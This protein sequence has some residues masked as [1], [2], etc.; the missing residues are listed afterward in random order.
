M[1]TLLGAGPRRRD[2]QRLWFYD[3]GPSPRSFRTITPSPPR[4]DSLYS[5]FPSLAP[6]PPPMRSPAGPTA[7]RARRRRH[8][9]TWSSAPNHRRRPSTRL[10]RAPSRLS[11]TATTPDHRPGLYGGGSNSK[12]GQDRTWEVAYNHRGRHHSRRVHVVQEKLADALSCQPDRVS[13]AAATTSP[14]ST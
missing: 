5:C 6:S 11:A 14:S 12:R 2:S 8:P 13:I 4:C 3:L 1:G 9:R 7:G 10:F